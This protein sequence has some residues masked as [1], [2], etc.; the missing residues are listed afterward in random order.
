MPGETGV[1][2]FFMFGKEKMNHIIRQ[3]DHLGKVYCFFIIPNVKYL[4]QVPGIAVFLCA[5]LVMLPKKN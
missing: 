5:F 4:Q 3:N 1:S 2:P